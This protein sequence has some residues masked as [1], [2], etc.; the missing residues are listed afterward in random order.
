M[1]PS[2]SGMSSSS[3]PSCANGGS[4]P[5]YKTEKKAQTIA[6]TFF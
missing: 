3:L 5:T 6:F 2:A 4:H 1:K